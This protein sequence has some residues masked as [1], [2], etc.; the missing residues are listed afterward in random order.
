LYE[1]V[2]KG[3]FSKCHLQKIL[4]NICKVKERP[5]L[6]MPHKSAKIRSGL[7]NTGH[8]SDKYAANQV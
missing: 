4:K 8:L 5:F 7:K 6:P 2:E 1:W 3:V